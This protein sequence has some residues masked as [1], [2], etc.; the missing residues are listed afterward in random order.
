MDSI[1]AFTFEGYGLKLYGFSFLFIIFNH[2]VM[3]RNL[4]CSENL[5]IILLLIITVNFNPF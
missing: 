4:L 3:K 2:F 1:D 5:F